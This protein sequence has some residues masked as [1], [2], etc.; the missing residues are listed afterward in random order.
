MN[1]KINFNRQFDRNC[2]EELCGAGVRE[3]QNRAWKVKIGKMN[4]SLFKCKTVRINSDKK[5]VGHDLGH[6]KEIEKRGNR[7][8]F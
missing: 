4:P 3:G 2:S 7:F 1:P 8:C 6:E 5:C